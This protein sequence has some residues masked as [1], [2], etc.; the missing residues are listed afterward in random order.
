[1]LSQIMQVTSDAV[2]INDR[3]VA[4]GTA[5]SSVFTFNLGIVSVHEVN[6]PSRRTTIAASWHSSRA[7]ACFAAELLGTT[8]QAN[9][10]QYVA[11]TTMTYVPAFALTC[12]KGQRRDRTQV[13]V[14]S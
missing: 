6:R 5:V 10:L 14:T 1:M 13:Q 2:F 3:A 11:S 12:W 9:S 4:N 7:R 8:G